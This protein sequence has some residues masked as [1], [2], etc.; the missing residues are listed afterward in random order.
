[1][2]AHQTKTPLSMYFRGTLFRNIEYKF[3]RFF[4]P[5]RKNGYWYERTYNI[6]LN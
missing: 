4:I 3:D 6:I 2:K 5:Y 1:M